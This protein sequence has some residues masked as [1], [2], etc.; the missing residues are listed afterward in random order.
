MGPSDGLTSRRLE[1]L[2]TERPPLNTWLEKIVTYHYTLTISVRST[3]VV[4]TE[5]FVDR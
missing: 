2:E 3:S 4:A 5:H 1:N